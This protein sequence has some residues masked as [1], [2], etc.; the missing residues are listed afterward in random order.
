M[1][2]AGLGRPWGVVRPEDAVISTELEPEEKAEVG[3]ESIRSDTGSTFVGGRSDMR[4]NTCEDI[5]DSGLSSALTLIGSSRLCWLEKKTKI[6]IVYTN[7][8]IKRVF[9]F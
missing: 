3:E 5:W 6:K 9:T 4:F 7:L 1:L 2:L 8:F